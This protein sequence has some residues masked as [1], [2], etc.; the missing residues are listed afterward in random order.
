MLF[1]IGGASRSGKS[2][3]A[4][5]IRASEGIPWFSLDVLR[6]GLHLGAP[7]LGLDPYADDLEE[8]DHLWP[9]VRAMIDT[10]LYD[11]RPYLM[12]GVCLRPKTVAALAKK[13]A[14]R[15][16]ACFLGY[17]DLDTQQKVSHV[18]TYAGG[19]NDWLSNND[20]TFILR[21]VE[22]CRIVSAKLRNECRNAGMPFFDTGNDFSVGIAAA[23]NY[24]TG[25]V[26]CAK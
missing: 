3:L 23:A 4:E 2:L 21:Y 6:T 5:R 1:L 13:N 16:A 26:H 18:V 20:R 19:P 15:I 22:K 25:S 14:G 8:G 7:E 12:E 24:L 9:I 10:V 17:P 11:G